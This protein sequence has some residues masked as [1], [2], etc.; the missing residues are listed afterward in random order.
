LYLL[1]DLVSYTPDPQGRDVAAEAAAATVS[2]GP[3][4]TVPAAPTTTIAVPVAAA[5]VEAVACAIL[6][7]H[8]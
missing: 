4:A 8:V 5:V 6:L 7:N 3:T 2:V 1:F